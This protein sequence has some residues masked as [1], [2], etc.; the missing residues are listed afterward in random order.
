MSIVRLAMSSS[1]ISRI[2]LTRRFNELRARLHGDRRDGTQQSLDIIDR[3]DELHES[4]PATAHSVLR[5]VLSLVLN[6]RLPDR[7]RS[8]VLVL[9]HEPGLN[10]LENAYRR[11]IVLIT[12]TQR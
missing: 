11:G 6:D 10:E 12:A 2:E 7:L 3:L 1:G 8:R 9:D 5:E 4:A